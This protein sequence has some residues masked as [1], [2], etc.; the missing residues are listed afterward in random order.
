K[1]RTSRVAPQ[2]NDAVRPEITAWRLV[3][4][5][6][7]WILKTPLALFVI[8]A[9]VMI[10]SVVRLFL[11]FS[12][13]YFRLIEIPEAAFGVIG[14]TVGG[15]GLAVSPLARRMVA[16]NSVARNYSLLALT[17]LAGLI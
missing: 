12:S 10:D 4:N 14:A 2:T 13:S 1:A 15:L 8:T 5:A 7:A 17:V 11:T 9:G 3:A 6:G 16:K